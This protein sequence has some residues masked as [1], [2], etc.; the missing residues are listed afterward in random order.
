MVAKKLYEVLLPVSLCEESTKDH[1]S[2]SRLKI[3]MSG[4]EEE[5]RLASKGI[6]ED[7]LVDMMAEP[8]K[9]LRPDS[10]SIRSKHLAP[11]QCS[12]PW[13][14][15]RRRDLVPEPASSTSFRPLR[16]FLPS[17]F[18][19]PDPKKELASSSP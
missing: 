19:L 11:C 9:Q 8:T 6:L 16:T 15:N 13:C 7:H 2:R 14:R 3:P 10:C 18:G 4:P 5:P 1:R 12:K 17:Q